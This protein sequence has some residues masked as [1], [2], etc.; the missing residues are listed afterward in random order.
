MRNLIL[1]LILTL[2]ATTTLFAD[3]NK[4]EEQRRIIAKLEASIAK[5]ERELASLKKNKASKQ[6]L[7]NS[8]IRQIEQR[9]ALINATNRQLKELNREIAASSARIDEL[10]GQLLEL[11]KSCAEMARA[12]Y[13]NY[14]FNNTLTYL[15][16]SSSTADFARRLASLRI[17]TER[18]SEQIKR[19]T[20]VREDV[21]R[22]REELD[23]KRSEA[24]AAKKKL[25]RER[26]RLRQNR[27]EA[28]R[29]R[30][31]CR[32]RSA[33]FCNPRSSNRR[34]SKQQSKSYAN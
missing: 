9:N 14:R 21:R 16:S 2:M 20:S 8:L 30:D 4:V 29:E 28:K 10:S 32:R 33:M 23:K 7:V 11:E 27:N 25:D 19:I 18:R 17:A 34:N 5:E 1:T 12:A 3:T 26:E 13:R 6:K 31:K 24:S 15:L 22:E